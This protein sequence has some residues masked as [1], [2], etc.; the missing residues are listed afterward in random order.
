MVRPLVGG[1]GSD[2]SA[3]WRW[4]WDEGG[5]LEGLQWG[6]QERRVCGGRARLQGTWRGRAEAA[7]R[8]GSACELP[9][10]GP[11]LVWK[12][13]GSQRRF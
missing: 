1:W 13:S 11:G 4:R 12:V 8:A 9:S 7:G 6:P 3:R 10:S 2:P 5:G